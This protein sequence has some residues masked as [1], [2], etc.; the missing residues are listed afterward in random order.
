MVRELNAPVTEFRTLACINSKN[1]ANMNNISGF[2]K[3]R[4]PCP[5]G[6]RHD[7]IFH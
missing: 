5:A 6:R 1:R 7:I 3:A 2:W 4:G